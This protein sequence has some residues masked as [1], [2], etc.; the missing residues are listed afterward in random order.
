VAVAAVVT[1]AL[2]SW[3]GWLAQAAGTTYV[4]NDV[5]PPETECGTPNYTTTDINSVIALPEVNDGDTLV[6]CEGTYQPGITVNKEIAIEG[7]AVVDIDKIVID[8]TA[9]GADGLTVSANNVTVR[10]LMLDGPGGSTADDGIV[11][12]HGTD[13]TTISDV[14]VTEWD[15]GI[16]VDDSAGT[17]IEYSNIHGNDDDNDAYGVYLEA[18]ERSV[19]RHNQIADNGRTGIGVM[20]E[21][22]ALVIDNTISGNADDQIAVFEESHVRIHRNEIV[23]VT[24]SDGI[25]LSWS[26]PA[27][28]FVQIGG[29]PEN[30]NTFSGPFDPGLGSYYVHMLCDAENTVDATYNWWGSTNPIDIANR[31]LNDEDDDGSECTMPHDGSVVFHP[32]ATGPAPTPSPSP[33]PTPTPSPTATP[34]PTPV[35]DTRDFDLPIGWNNFVWTGADD[36]AADTALNCIAGNFA[37]AYGLE[38]GGWLRYVPGQPDITTLATVDKYDN[39]LVLITASGVQCLEMPVDP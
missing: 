34:S 33:T 13:N 6:L 39:L 27:E 38:A 10:H 17:V 37:I 32:W 16:F 21:D 22:E 3:Q 31:I 36:T 28:A 29:S 26:L 1:I 14:E 35:A 5:I 30:A 18:G 24:N 7:Q 8:G 4:I 23:T 25:F 2:G 11:V 20:D 9:G 19:V 15:T 12:I